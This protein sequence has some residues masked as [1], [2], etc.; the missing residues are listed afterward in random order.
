MPPKTVAAMD[1]ASPSCYHQSPALVLMQKSRHDTSCG[2]GNRVERKP[3]Y[4]SGFRIRAT[5]GC[6]TNKGKSRAALVACAAK[7]C[8][9]SSNRHSSRTSRTASFMTCC[10][11]VAPGEG[12]GSRGSDNAVE[13]GP[14]TGA[15]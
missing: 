12:A 13:G 1:G 15:C 2:I 9:K 14:T 5:N 10:Q 6:G 3:F 11:D 4:G 8:G 7:L